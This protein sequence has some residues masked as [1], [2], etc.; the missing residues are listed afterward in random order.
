MI[1]LW[2]FIACGCVWRCVKDACDA[3]RGMPDKGIV[4]WSVGAFL[5]RDSWQPKAMLHEIT[6]SKQTKLTPRVYRILYGLW[7]FVG[8]WSLNTIQLQSSSLIWCSNQVCG[9]LMVAVQFVSCFAVFQ[10]HVGRETIEPMT[11]CFVIFKVAQVTWLWALTNQCQVATD[12][13]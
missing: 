1:V 13:E 7:M 3:G 8:S 2:I 12:W 9:L 11:H 10:Q 5:V 6:Q 4:L